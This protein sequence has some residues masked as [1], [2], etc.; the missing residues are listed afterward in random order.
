MLTPT[1][2]RSAIYLDFEGEGKKR[3]G[4]VP[5]PHMAGTLRPNATG[6]GGK[7]SC[8]F[9]KQCWKPASDGIPSS[10][11]LSFRD[12]FEILLS[13]L[14][15]KNC[16][17]VYWTMHESMILETYLEPELYV[18]LAPYLVNLHPLAKTYASR[19]RSFG[20]QASAKG[21]SLEDFL[22][23]LYKKRNPYPPFPLGPAEA[24]RR[25]DVATRKNMNWKHFSDKQKGYVKD[26]IAY[27]LGD[28]RSTWLIAKRIGNYYGSRKRL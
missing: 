16:H 12:Y 6:G 21:R 24:C 3:D 1:E 18:R 22:G 17:L 26:L 10:E 28:C 23:A 20:H 27:N 4:T 15:E 14:K 2:F 9:F 7:Y 13:E 11:C 19:R 5:M 8:V 25:V